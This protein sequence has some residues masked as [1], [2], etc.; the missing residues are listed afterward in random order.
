MG[1]NLFSTWTL[2]DEEKKQKDIY[3]TKFEE[4][5]RPKSNK[6]YARFRL[7]SRT[8]IENET[9]DQFVRVEASCQDYGYDTKL[10]EMVCDHIVFGVKSTKIQEKLIQKGTG[11]TLDKAID[12][13]RTYEL[14]LAQLQA[15]SQDKLA[16]TIHYV[17]GARRQRPKPDVTNSKVGTKPKQAQVQKPTHPG[18]CAKCRNS[19]PKRQCPASGTN[20]GKNN[21]MVKRCEN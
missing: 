5:C 8:Q 11:L 19:H 3:F 20:A 18:K 21:G 4:Y 12:I 1:C 14:S 7:R 6:I 2:T 16:A 15:I 17:K 9:F 10:E 13:A